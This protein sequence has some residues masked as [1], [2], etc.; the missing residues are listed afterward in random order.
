MKRV[1]RV[2]ICILMTL[3]IGTLAFGGCANT[4]GQTAA[5]EQNKEEAAAPAETP[6]TET[7]APK[8][9][10]QPAETEPSEEPAI[11]AT[12]NQ[13]EN[14][15]PEEPKELVAEFEPNPDYDKYT[16]VYY[17][18]DDIDARFVATVSAKDDDSEY[19]VH[20]SV[21]GE[22]QIVTLDKDLVI[23]KD[24]TGNMFF[25]APRIAEKAVKTGNWSPIN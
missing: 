4:G 17:I 20:C 3:I 24:L 14:A 12:G 15:E 6:A 11:A 19:E 9:E 1:K 5:P 25:D 2:N 23:T 21:D 8:E 22:E 7:E 18:V 10:T 13:A 16:L